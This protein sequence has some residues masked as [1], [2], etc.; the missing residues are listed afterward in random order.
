MRIDYLNS[1][2]G[3]G[4]EAQTIMVNDIPEVKKVSKAHKDEHM[5]YLVFSGLLLLYV[6]VR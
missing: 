4:T 6:F 5:H 3:A 2:T 1:M